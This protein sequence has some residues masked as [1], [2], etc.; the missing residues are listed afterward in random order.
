VAIQELLERF[1]LGKL[2]EA[3]T[4]EL[5]YGTPLLFE[6]KKSSLAQAW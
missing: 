5:K 3:L 6:A 1:E 4:I 2:K